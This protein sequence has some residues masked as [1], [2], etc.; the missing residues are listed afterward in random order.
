MIIPC[1]DAHVLE[2]SAHVSLKGATEG[3][4]RGKKNRKCLLLR[5][6]S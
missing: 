2:R 3:S 1:L 4:F 6:F 5:L